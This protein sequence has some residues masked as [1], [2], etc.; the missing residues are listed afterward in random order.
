MRDEVQGTRSSGNR[1]AGDCKIK[2]NWRLRPSVKAKRLSARWLL[3]LSCDIVTGHA[4]C[5]G[6]KSA[7]ISSLSCEVSWFTLE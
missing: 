5:I 1:A 2:A 3:H 7:S 6:P 4:R